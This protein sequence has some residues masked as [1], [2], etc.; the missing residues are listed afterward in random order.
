MKRVADCHG[1][2]NIV[3]V[4]HSQCMQNLDSRMPN[5]LGLRFFVLF[6]LLHLVFLSRK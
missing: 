3:N 6:L 2:E 4:N 1:Y 5:R